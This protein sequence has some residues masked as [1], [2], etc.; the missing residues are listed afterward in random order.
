MSG[1]GDSKL[2]S[3]SPPFSP[4]LFSI[5]LPLYHLTKVTLS[6]LFFATL[7]SLLDLTSP[8][9]DRTWA[10]AVKVPSPNHGT[11][12]EF[13]PKSTLFQATSHLFI[14]RSKSLTSFEL[15]VTFFTVDRPYFSKAKNSPASSYLLSCSFSVSFG[16]SCPV[17]VWV[18][19]A[20]WWLPPLP[21]LLSAWQ[22][23]LPPE[24]FMAVFS[25]MAAPRLEL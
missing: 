23:P 4:Q 13:P 12:R 11:A 21:L 2:G 6:L 8:T 15:T 1:E 14:G 17:S 7:C 10:L 16:S 18:P 22:D 20:L 5:W 9:G 25:L 19:V 3:R 24:A